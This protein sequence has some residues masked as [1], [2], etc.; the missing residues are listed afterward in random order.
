MRDTFFCLPPERWQI[1]PL[2]S[3]T[4]LQ[5]GKWG[6]AR[7]ACCCGADSL[8]LGTQRAKQGPSTRETLSLAVMVASLKGSLGSAHQRVHEE[9]SPEEAQPA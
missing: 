7:H 9:G 2:S 3:H 6:A 1:N 5:Y 4:C 8:G